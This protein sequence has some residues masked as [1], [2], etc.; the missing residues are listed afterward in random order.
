MLLG[1]LWNSSTQ[2]AQPLARP[3]EDQEAAEQDVQVIPGC[4]LLWS[5]QGSHLASH[6]CEGQLS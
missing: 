2:R 3:G 4:E 6:R 1:H 5:G